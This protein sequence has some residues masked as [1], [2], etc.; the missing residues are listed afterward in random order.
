MAPW[1]YRASRPLLSL[2]RLEHWQTDC[3]AVARRFHFEWGEFKKLRQEPLPLQLAERLDWLAR[4]VERLPPH[5]N[6][7]DELWAEIRAVAREAL[8]SMRTWLK[9]Y[10]LV[11][12]Y[13][14]PAVARLE[15]SGLASTRPQ[16]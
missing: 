7:N 11:S 13:R 14:N 1:N 10:R 8:P 2:R 12:Y 3:E 4:L 9:R 5:S 15:V 16:S 6:F